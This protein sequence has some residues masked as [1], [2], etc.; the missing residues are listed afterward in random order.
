MDPPE[1]GFPP[2]PTVVASGRPGMVT[3]A[4]VVLIVIG[5]LFG[6]IGLLFLLV[7]SQWRSLIENPDVRAQIGELPADFGRVVVV[8][9][10]IVI[11]IGTVEILSGAFVLVA[12]QWARITG[13]VIS[14]VLGLFWVLN[15]VSP[16]AGRWLP[17]LLLGSSAFVV[18][19]LATNGRYF[20]RE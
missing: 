18:W 5:A 15:V 13:I 3:A 19:A 14:S 4:G 17:M 8:I 20:S 6:L 12:R 11:V 9:G 1:I 7:G 16:G 10:A 2:A